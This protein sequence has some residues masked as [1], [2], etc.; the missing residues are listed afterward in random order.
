MAN[1]VSP[2]TVSYSNCAQLVH[3]NEF[4]V[5]LLE[6]R[7]FRPFK[8]S[9]EYLYAM[10]EDLA[11]WLNTL[12]GL[13]INVDNFMKQLETG[14]VLC[15]HANHV[16]KRAREYEAN[17]RNS[18]NIPIPKKDIIFKLNVNPGTFQA[19]DN[20]SNFITWCRVLQI[21]E[22]LLFE[23]DDLVMRKNE[24]SFILCLLEVARRGSKF[25]ILAPTLV[26][27]EEEIDRELAEEDVE[28]SD[29][30]NEENIK[31][32]IITNDLRSLHE[33]VV[34]LLS[35]CSCPTQY[36]LEYIS[37][38]KYRIGDTKVLIFVRILRSHV[39]VRVGGGWDTL[40]HYLDKH[41]PCRCRSGHRYSYSARLS[42]TPS[43]SLSN[44]PQMQV[45]YSRPME[46][47]TST[48][49]PKRTIFNSRDVPQL[50]SPSIKKNLNNSSIGRD[51]NKQNGQ[52]R[53]SVNDSNPGFIVQNNDYS[54]N[55]NINN[56]EIDSSFEKINRINNNN[57]PQHNCSTNELH[58]SHP[59]LS[60]KTVVDCS[61]SEHSEN[62]S[63]LAEYKKNDSKVNNR[64]KKCSPRKILKVI[65]DLDNKK[66]IQSNRRYSESDESSITSDEVIT[67]KRHNNRISPEVSTNYL[68]QNKANLQI[69]RTNGL[70]HGF[71]KSRDILLKS[72]KSQS[73]DDVRQI[74]SNKVN[75]NSKSSYTTGC[76]PKMS[77]INSQRRSSADS[78]QLQCN[79]R[80]RYG[81]FPRSRSQSSQLRINDSIPNKTNQFSY[82][83][84]S[85]NNSDKKS[86]SF[87]VNN[88]S[89]IT[90]NSCRE[91][92]TWTFKQRSRLPLNDDLYDPNISHKNPI[93][94]FSDTENISHKT[95]NN[96]SLGSQ[97]SLNTSLSTDNG[98][99]RHKLSE[100]LKQNQNEIKQKTRYNY[101]VS[102]EMESYRESNP[103]KTVI[104]NGKPYV[105][106][107]PT[108]L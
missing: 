80:Y 16:L 46:A 71:T 54:L 91:V 1:S 103:N 88:S 59:K 33:R 45:I 69:N 6:P 8:T 17:G 41:D 25:G 3:D 72:N 55:S 62:E 53:S 102:N 97:K 98:N 61:S 14:V 70:N 43:K 63:K 31:K 29:N 52:R 7:P 108:L 93:N 12:Y 87:E 15:R 13:N 85:I 32:Q 81:S 49:F 104:S 56:D 2:K 48:N 34:E 10:K 35:R 76:I 21:H 40:E 107:I 84:Q 27:F 77:Y 39:M 65:E 105:S 96:I 75:E 83:K 94:R 79:G 74:D 60:Q 89:P 38:G 42:L 73:S 11:E 92:K 22:C 78:S 24:K 51:I 19:R 28:N 86:K 47:T 66:S 57:S 99:N 90:S 26:Q 9:E 4:Q 95:K 101:D 36:N 50:L 23:T 20:V 64:G 67:S 68:Q 106:K 58:K 5:M 82:S 37:D 30:K 18:L 100:K 44:S